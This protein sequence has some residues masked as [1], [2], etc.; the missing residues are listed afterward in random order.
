M[1]WLL[2]RLALQNLGRRKARAALLMSA[3]AISTAIAF[4]GIVLMRSIETSMTIGFSRLGADLMVV[5]ADTLTNITASLLTVEPSDQTL[6]ADLLDRARISGIAHAAPQRILR[7]RDSG[8]GAHGDSVDLIGIDVSR[9]F[10]VQ[11]WIVERLGRPMQP[12]DVILGAARDAPLGSEI[13]LFGKPFHVYAKLGRTGVGT[14]ER[15]IFISSAAFTDLAGAIRSR[16]G[17]VPAIVVPGKA[18]GFLIQLAPGTTE[19]QVRFALL[20]RLSGIKVISGESMWTGIRQGLSALFGVTLA[21]IA[22][23]F[24]SIAIMAGVLFSAIVAERRHEFGLLKAIGARRRQIAGMVLMEAMIATGAGGI[25]GVIF[26]VLLLRAFERSLVYY[27]TEIGIPFVWLDMRNTV[28]TG[29]VC[30]LAAVLTGAIGAFI[31]AQRV[32]RRDAYELIM[33][34]G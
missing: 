17:A 30:V 14:H 12:D 34:E 28:A 32:S 1:R 3:V 7:T 23:T 26:G 18:S 25:V 19:L 15:G 11:P 9:D 24:G 27:L 8:F 31:P 5:P 29:I 6:D 21:L 10:T 4:T 33:G 16:T 22:L 2:T 13:V 20:S